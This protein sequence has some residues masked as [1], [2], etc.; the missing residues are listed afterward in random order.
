MML[1]GSAPPAGSC[2]CFLR[3][4]FA[5]FIQGLTGERRGAFVVRESDGEL[6]EAAAAAAGGEQARTPSATGLGSSPS[7]RTSFE[8]GTRGRGEEGDAG[9]GWHTLG[10]ANADADTRSGG[11]RGHKK[12]GDGRSS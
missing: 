6:A 5:G 7:L 10:G 12:V 1:A 8:A 9:G 4:G 11:S 2:D 3:A